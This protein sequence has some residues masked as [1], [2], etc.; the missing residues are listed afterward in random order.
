MEMMAHD[1]AWEVR[2]PPDAADLFLSG[3]NPY[4]PS[5]LRVARLAAPAALPAALA[6][7]FEKQMTVDEYL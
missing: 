4:A 3:S 5:T 2:G 1:S 7:V 6:H